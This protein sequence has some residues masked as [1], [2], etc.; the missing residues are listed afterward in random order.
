MSGRPCFLAGLLSVSP[1][2]LTIRRPGRTLNRHC[3]AVAQ[4]LMGA[5]LIHLTGGRLETHFHVFGSLVAFLAFYR[6]WRVLVT[7]SAVV[8]VDHCL[9]GLF[10]PQSVLRRADGQPLALAG[11]RGLGRFSRIAFS[12]SPAAAASG[13]PRRC[14]APGPNWKPP[15]PRSSRLSRPAPRN[16]AS[17]PCSFRISSGGSSRSSRPRGATAFVA[18]GRQRRG[19]GMEQ[20]SRGQLRDGPSPMRL[21]AVW[22]SCWP[23]PGQH[24]AL[25]RDLGSLLTARG[26]AVNRPD[27]MIAAR[28]DGTSFPVEV[29]IWPIC[30]R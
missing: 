22:R 19:H 5:L 26:A 12:S 7:G 29:T 9:R 1:L 23:C 18:T 28:S 24:E 30:V 11:A 8:A 25:E 27:E 20:A 3:V 14:R 13:D 6:D 17:G 2:F 4:M 21:G 10:F 15:M 16:F